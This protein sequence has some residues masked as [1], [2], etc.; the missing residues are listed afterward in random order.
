VD[1]AHCFIRRIIDPPSEARPDHRPALTARD[2]TQTLWSV[3]KLS[4]GPTGP[5]ALQSTYDGAF[6]SDRFEDDALP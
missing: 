2:V 4:G 5:G 3:E 6:V 1:Y